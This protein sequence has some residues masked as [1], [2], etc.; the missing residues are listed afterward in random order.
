[1]EAQGCVSPSDLWFS[2]KVWS[3]N[4][5]TKQHT[6]K[7]TKEKRKAS[8]S[9]YQAQTH[10]H[11]VCGPAGEVWNWRIRGRIFS[12]RL[13]SLSNRSRPSVGLVVCM[14]VCVCEYVYLKCLELSWACPDVGIIWLVLWRTALKVLLGKSTVKERRHT[15]AAIFE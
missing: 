7:E 5:D 4:K 10:T 2:W 11:T 6:M 8:E 15:G 12:L 14:C 13:A 1:M 9:L 3:K